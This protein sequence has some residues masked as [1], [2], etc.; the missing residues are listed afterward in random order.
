MLFHEEFLRCPECNGSYFKKESF[1]QLNKEA[2]Q[3]KDETKKIQEEA[4]LIEYTCKDCH[5][6]IYTDKLN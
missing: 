5:K 2:F 3:L 4:K 6:V 1:V